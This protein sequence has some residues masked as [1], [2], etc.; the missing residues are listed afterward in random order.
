MRIECRERICTN[1]REQKTTETE[2]ELLMKRRL[3]NKIK[4][5]L[6]TIDIL[7]EVF[8]ELKNIGGKHKVIFFQWKI[9]SR[10]MDQIL[11][12]LSDDDKVRLCEE[13]EGM[14]KYGSEVQRNEQTKELNNDKCCMRERREEETKM[15][16]EWQKG[17]SNR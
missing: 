17:S 14:T 10:V 1:G 4:G 7:P 15:I 3:E 2:E 11:K 8:E 13:L 6:L 12:I 5:Q 16:L 9:E